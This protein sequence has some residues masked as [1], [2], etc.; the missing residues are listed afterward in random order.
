MFS[1]LAW[2]IIVVFALYGVAT[3][4]CEFYSFLIYGKK[5]IKVAKMKIYLSGDTGSIEYLMRSVAHLFSNVRLE[6]GVPEITVTAEDMSEET[7]KVLIA[8]SQDFTNVDISV[9]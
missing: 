5:S 2:T 9:I 1:I 8:L 4:I 3:S 7:R 6:E